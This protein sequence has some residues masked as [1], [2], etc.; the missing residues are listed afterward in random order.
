MLTV[1]MLN[2]IMLGVIR[3]SAIMLSIVM[4]GFVNLS[5]VMLNVYR[6][7]G[8]LLSFVY[9]FYSWH[10]SAVSLSLLPLGDVIFAQ[11]ACLPPPPE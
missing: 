6:E 8:W 7:I 4:L 9:F 11:L 2:V 3:P 5:V 10:A 1:V